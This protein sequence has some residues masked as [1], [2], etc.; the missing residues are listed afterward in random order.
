MVP[1]QLERPGG[2]CEVRRLKRGSLGRFSC[3][4]NRVPEGLS[5]ELGPSGQVDRGSA[6]RAVSY[7][8]L[9]NLG[10]ALSSVFVLAG[11]LPFLQLLGGF[12]RS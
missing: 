5:P 4:E 1:R 2:Y 6:D 8:D 10:V 11:F 7:V 9:K 12:F 3:E